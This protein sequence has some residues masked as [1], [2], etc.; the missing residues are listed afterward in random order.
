MYFGS[1]NECTPCCDGSSPVRNVARVAL[2]A[3]DNWLFRKVYWW[4]VGGFMREAADREE[5]LPL[6]YQQFAAAPSTQLAFFRLTEDLFSTVRDRTK[7]IPQMKAFSRPMRIIFGAKDP[8]LNAGVARRFH[9]LFPTSDL[10]LLPE[11][12]HFVQIDEP[13]QVAHLLLSTERTA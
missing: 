13:E 1:R 2:Q 9:E 10:F 12:N 7:R 3:F 11:A 5:F 6:L 4:Q 8:Y